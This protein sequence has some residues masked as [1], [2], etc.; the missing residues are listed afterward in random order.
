MDCQS[1]RT[2]AFSCVE[3]EESDEKERD[4]GMISAWSFVRDRRE[5]EARGTER[6]SKW[7]VQAEQW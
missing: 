2:L 1:A 3:D 5:R 4:G 7:A 6:E